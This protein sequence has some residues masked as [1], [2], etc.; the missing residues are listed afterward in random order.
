MAKGYQLNKRLLADPSP[1]YAIV[2][3]IE[4]QKNRHD[5]A[6]KQLIQFVE[7]WLNMES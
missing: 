2:S 1:E 4:T 3:L 7:I 5:Q 6:R